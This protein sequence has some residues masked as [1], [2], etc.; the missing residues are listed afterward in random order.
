VIKTEEKP[1]VCEKCGTTKEIF[2]F[3]DSPALCFTCNFKIQEGS[4]VK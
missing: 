4:Y 1:L 3:K 2:K